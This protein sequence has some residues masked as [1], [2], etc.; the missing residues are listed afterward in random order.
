M[1]EQTKK[2]KNYSASKLKCYNSCEL[3]YDLLYN[4][5]LTDLNDVGS[6][7]AYKGTVFHKFAENIASYTNLNLRI[8]FKNILEETLKDFDTSKL[9][10][11]SLTEACQNFLNWWKSKNFN[12]EDWT[13]IPEKYEQWSIGKVKLTGIIDLILI[14]KKDNSI[15][16]I[17]YKTSKS[18]DMSR[19][20]DQLLTYSFYL[21]EKF[22]INI[23]D[24]SKK[25]SLNIYYP[26]IINSD[27]SELKVTSSMLSEFRCK[28]EKTAEEI[29]SKT[30]FYPK[31]NFMCKFCIF[32]G[33]NEY[34]QMSMIL[35]QKPTP[36]VR[37][38]NKYDK[39]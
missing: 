28:V 24:F 19:H 5:H 1:S 37:I 16:L 27:L 11:P 3:Q 2:Q 26:Y 31:P 32:S 21:M 14:N 15:I 29:E 34:C 30:N 7:E 35:G 10:I 6:P 4:K 22:N 17:D 23:S 25:V 38:G 20:E 39:K 13:I 33:S 18:A 36:G 8:I 9:D 12:P